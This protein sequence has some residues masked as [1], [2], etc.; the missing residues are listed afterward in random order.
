M[1]ER[2]TTFEIEGKDRYAIQRYAGDGW[3]TVTGVRPNHEWDEGTMTLAPG[4]SVSWELKGERGGMDYGP[5][6]M[7]LLPGPDRYRFVYWGIPET[8]TA[9]YTEFEIASYSSDD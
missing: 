7:C 6:E 5:V 1:N 9:L 4:E 8:D 2:S 3:K